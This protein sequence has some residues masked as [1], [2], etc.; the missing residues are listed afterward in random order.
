MS[1]LSTTRTLVVAHGT[2]FDSSYRHHGT[3]ADEE[4]VAAWRRLEP[5]RAAQARGREAVFRDYRL[6]IASVVRD[7]GK[8]ERGEVPG[9]SRAF[10]G[11][12]TPLR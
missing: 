7:Y 3:R 4:A 1:R 8:H 10:H 9:D 6:R 5:H 2:G 11:D 12:T